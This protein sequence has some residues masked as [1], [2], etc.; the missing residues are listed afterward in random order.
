MLKIVNVVGAR[1]NFMKMAPIHRRMQHS[2]EFAPLLIHTGQHYD[3]RLS[4]SFFRDLGMPEPDRYLGVGSGSHA[5]QTAQVMVDMEKVLLEFRPDWIVVVGD[6]NSTLAA[7]LAAVKLHIPIAHVEAGLR[8]GDRQ[9]PEEINRILTDSIAD[10]LFVTEKSGLDHLCAEGRHGAGVHLV[11]NVMIDSLVEQ[12]PFIE[13]DPILE[14]MGLR[15]ASF[16]LLTLHRPSNVDDPQVFA[17]IVEALD[18]LQQQIELV[19]PIHPRTEKMA[20]QFGLLARLQ[21]MNNLR[22]LPPLGYLPFVRL[23]KNARLMLTDSGGVQEE[24]TFFGVPCLTL[25]ENTERPITIEM[26]T[27]RLV[28]SNTA[29]IVAASQPFLNG[30]TAQFQIPPLWDG[31]ASQRIV[32]IFAALN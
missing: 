16:A 14:S 22:L 12:L 9:M 5:V 7:A 26:G 3:D 8:S 10:L 32:E 1:P 11:G 30:G 29:A 21:K 15:P 25:R 31:Q 23:M 18:L 24:T 28:G 20:G 4:R 13:Q 6:V 27:N 19:F 2:N 17:A